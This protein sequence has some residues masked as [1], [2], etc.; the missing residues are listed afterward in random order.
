MNIKLGIAKYKHIK[1]LLDTRASSSIESQKFVTKLRQK[2]SKK[3]NGILLQEI[4]LQIIF[5]RM[6]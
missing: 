3:Q 6:I 2:Y 5:F 1:I 4:F